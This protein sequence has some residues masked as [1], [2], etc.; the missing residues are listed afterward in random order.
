MVVLEQEQLFLGQEEPE[1]LGQTRVRADKAAY[2]QLTL[3]LLDGFLLE[4]ILLIFLAKEVDL[5]THTF[6]D[7]LLGV[8]YLLSFGSQTCDVTS[9]KSTNK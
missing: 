2:V 8:F 1:E 5:A 3:K 9:L 6:P 4:A 7:R